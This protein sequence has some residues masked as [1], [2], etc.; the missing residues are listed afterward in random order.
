MDGRSKVEDIRL[1]LDRGCSTTDS[2][3]FRS[4]FQQCGLVLHQPKTLDPHIPNALLHLQ[5]PPFS[6]KQKLHSNSQTRFLPPPS[7]WLQAP[8]PPRAPPAGL[9]FAGAPGELWPVEAF[10]AKGPNRLL[11]TGAQGFRLRKGQSEVSLC[12]FSEVFPV[13]WTAKGSVSIRSTVQAQAVYQKKMP[14]KV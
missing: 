13:R 4:S 3:H 9:R 11:L 12:C 10:D 8:R 14:R 5:N 2:V 6:P 7:A 1:Y